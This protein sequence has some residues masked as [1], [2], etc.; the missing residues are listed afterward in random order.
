MEKQEAECERDRVRVEKLEA[1]SKIER[2]RLEKQEIEREGLPPSLPIQG[3]IEQ[4]T[5]ENRELQ[6]QFQQRL[7]KLQ[8]VVEQE[9]IEKLELQHQLRKVESVLN[10]T[11]DALTMEQETRK[12]EQLQYR[13]MT[14][15][16]THEI[17]HSL[18][19]THIY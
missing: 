2:A 10:I 13:K 1:E 7:D 19:N 5:M 15:R 17:M 16:V 8:E 18:Y 3:V 14:E 12:V 4:D 9:R 6:H 11:K